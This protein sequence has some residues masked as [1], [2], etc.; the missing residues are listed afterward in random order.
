M[1]ELATDQADL[2]PPSAELVLFRIH[3][4]AVVAVLGRRKGERYLRLMAQKLAAEENLSSLFP[5]RPQKDFASVQRARRQAA[6]IFE[7]L[8][9]VFLAR[10]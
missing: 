1:P 5:I 6:A 3:V 4:E 2:P 7:R 10:L 8:L 9:P